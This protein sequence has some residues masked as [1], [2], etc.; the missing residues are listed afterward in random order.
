M[1][2]TLLESRTKKERNQAVTAASVTVHGV[3]IVIAAFATATGA[4]AATEREKP[5]K[6][7]WVAPPK[8]QMTIRQ[9]RLPHSPAQTSTLPNV[10]VSV[11]IPSVIPAVNIPLG[12][13]TKA[14][15]S[16][17]SG[18]ASNSTDTSGVS[19]PSD[20]RRAYTS[21]EV[22]VPVSALRGGQPDYPGAL[23]SAGVQGEVV[24]LFI[25]DESGRGVVESV[26]ILSATNDLFAASVRR[27]IPKMRFSAARIGSH[28]VPQLVQQ[29]FVFRLDR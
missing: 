25:V 17:P 23:R 13:V 24:A 2:S 6:I 11:D 29:L 26:R 7:V 12:T 8:P 9:V 18:P 16:E 4:P 28:A 10:A 5:T 20:G 21:N 27:A 22:E 15:F 14:D 1:L 3:L 19:G